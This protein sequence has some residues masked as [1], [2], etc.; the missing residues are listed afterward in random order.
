MKNTQNGYINYVNLNA[1]ADFSYLVLDVILNNFT[2]ASFI[3]TPYCNS[4]IHI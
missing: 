3:F 2:A 4:T 1:D